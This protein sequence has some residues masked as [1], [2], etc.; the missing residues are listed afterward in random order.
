[1]RAGIYRLLAGAIIAAIARPSVCNR[2]PGFGDPR[3]AQEGS[4]SG[5]EIKFN[6]VNRGEGGREA[7]VT[8]N[9]RGTN[10][11][12]NEDLAWTCMFL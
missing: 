1:M 7:S 8:W 2:R 6:G 12:A 4:A 5:V 3:R 10:G 9:E 11:H